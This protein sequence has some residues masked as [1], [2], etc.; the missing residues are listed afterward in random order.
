MRII[1]IAREFTNT[2][3]GRLTKDGPYSGEAFRKRFLEPSIDRGEEVLVD[4]SDVVGLPSSFLEEAFGGL[5]RRSN[6]RASMKELIKIK[7]ESAALKPYVH[8]IDRYIN[9][10]ANRVAAR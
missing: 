4:L 7:A 1:S 8:L 6:A 10:A 9:E 3:G 5:F 2:P